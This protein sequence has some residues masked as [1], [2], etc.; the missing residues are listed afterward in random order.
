MT[1]LFDLIVLRIKVSTQ[2]RH[3]VNDSG[4]TV[5]PLKVASY[6][7]LPALYVSIYFSS[8]Y[9]TASFTTT[10]RPILIYTKYRLNNP[11]YR[12]IG[13]LIVVT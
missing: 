2:A 7:W 10:I 13:A 6:A 1:Y 5:L 4:I 3:H 9:Y 12:P 11:P 8:I